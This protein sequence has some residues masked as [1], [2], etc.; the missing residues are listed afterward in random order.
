M[1]WDDRVIGQL[2]CLGILF[3]S[4]VIGN[5]SLLD[6]YAYIFIICTQKYVC[7]PGA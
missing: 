6:I 1:G 4:G 3:V 5:L 7:F 2:I